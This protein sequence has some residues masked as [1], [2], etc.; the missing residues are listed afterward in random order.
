M[1][2]ADCIA[3][4][5]NGLDDEEIVEDPINS[6]IYRISAERAMDSAAHE[7]RSTSWDV[8]QE[9]RDF[10]TYVTDPDEST[11]QFL[12]PADRAN[13]FQR[14]SGTNAYA[15]LQDVDRL[16]EFCLPHIEPTMRDMR[17]AVAQSLSAAGMHMPD[18]TDDAIKEHLRSTLQGAYLNTPIRRSEIAAS[19]SGNTWSNQV[20]RTALPVQYEY[21]TDAFKLLEDVRSA[22]Q[23][24]NLTLESVQYVDRYLLTFAQS[25]VTPGLIIEGF[26]AGPQRVTEHHKRDLATFSG[27]VNGRN[28]EQSGL[29]KSYYFPQ[30][31]DESKDAL[32]RPS[33]W[34]RTQAEY[35]YVVVRALETC[36]FR[37][38]TFEFSYML[39]FAA[40]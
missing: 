9:L 21:Q 15:W 24:G 1:D 5:V 18:L 40:V 2:C 25:L 19:I 39:F 33:F 16:H 34:Y 36:T 29:L 17:E 37:A 26:P 12:I 30:I 23:E 35:L 31:P 28:K 14:L 13:S 11:S 10:D 7:L 8:Q 27:I 20:V 3:A 22:F 32:A 38:S 6:L 4:D